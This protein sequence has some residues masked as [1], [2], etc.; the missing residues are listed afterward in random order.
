MNFYKRYHIC[1]HIPV[2]FRIYI[3]SSLVNRTTTDEIAHLILNFGQRNM[4]KDEVMKK[5]IDLP[6]D[7]G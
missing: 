7:Q 4:K 1:W 2:Y 5:S 6:E 3:S